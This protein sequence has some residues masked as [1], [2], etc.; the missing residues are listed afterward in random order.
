MGK[1]NGS[2]MGKKGE[3]GL[4]LFG[5]FWELEFRKIQ[6]SIV[7]SISAAAGVRVVS[8]D[9]GWV[10]ELGFLRFLGRSRE[11]LGFLGFPGDWK[12]WVF[13]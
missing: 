3:R 12:N 1:E 7:A 13:C 4:E 9:L 10:K 5:G 2:S 8:L 6:T 11:N